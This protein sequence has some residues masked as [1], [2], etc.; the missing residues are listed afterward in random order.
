MA[1]DKKKLCT[2]AS[3]DHP[4]F[5]TVFTT[6]SNAEKMP[7][8]HDFIARLNEMVPDKANL[9]SPDGRTWHVAVV[10]RGDR[11]FFKDG[12][13]KF[14]QENS[15]QL[16]DFI[17]FYYKGTNRFDIQLFGVSCCEKRKEGPQLRSNNRNPNPNPN[18]NPIQGCEGSKRNCKKT[19]VKVKHSAGNET[20]DE[21]EEEFDASKLVQPMNPWFKATPR[22]KRMNELFVPLDVLK[23][24]GFELP[25]EMTLIDPA[26]RQWD[27]NKV[28]EWKDGRVWIEG[29]VREVWQ[30]NQIR[31]NDTCV[32]EV[33]RGKNGVWGKIKVHK[34]K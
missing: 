6:V 3:H 11:F 27:G 34:L 1:R 15:L 22:P 16:G 10:S 20:E 23:Y 8:P 18:L 7:I 5:Y 32:C 24:I 31:I 25:P 17:V 19:R 12:W 21:E 28:V 13:S 26:G 4:A 14:I 30:W 9:R 2:K 33:I 29:R